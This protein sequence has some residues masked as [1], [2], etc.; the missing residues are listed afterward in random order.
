M[1]R[2]D[3]RTPVFLVALFTIART[4]KQPKFPWSEE[5]IK[6]MWYIYTMECYSDIKKKARMSFITTWMGPR[7]VISS[8]AVK[9]KYPMTSLICEI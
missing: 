3:T 7:I 6:K 4:S 8:E 5:W 9:D 1:I 2:K